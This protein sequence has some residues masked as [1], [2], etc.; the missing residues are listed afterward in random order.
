MAATASASSASS[1]AATEVLIHSGTVDIIEMA[2]VLIELVGGTSTWIRTVRYEP[3]TLTVYHLTHRDSGA[4]IAAAGGLNCGKPDEESAMGEAVY[5]AG[6]RADCEGKARIHGSGRSIGLWLRLQ[7]RF[8]RVGVAR[9]DILRK[10]RRTAC[11][12]AGLTAM[13]GPGAHD[14]RLRP[15]SGIPFSRCEWALYDESR[16][17]VECCVIEH[18]RERLNYEDL[19][20]P[21]KSLYDTKYAQV[22]EGLWKIDNGIMAGTSGVRGNCRHGITMGQPCLSCDLE[23]H[24][25]CGTALSFPGG[26]QV[27]VATAAAPVVRG[28]THLWIRGYSRRSRE[29]PKPPPLP[30]GWCPAL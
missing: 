8:G 9:T 24:A 6:S 30:D 25:G 29:A 4:S 2:P 7:V 15:S 23:R 26:P 13:W 27:L 18:A 17:M 12:A 11:L 5:C 10:V 1:A 20:E 16:R 19:P 28:P 3:S 21:F 14:Y 22:D